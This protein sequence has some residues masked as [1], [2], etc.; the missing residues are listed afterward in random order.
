M[1]AVP[2]VRGVARPRSIAMDGTFAMPIPKMP[3]GRKFSGTFVI[4]VG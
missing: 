2:F 3:T 4:L 1:A